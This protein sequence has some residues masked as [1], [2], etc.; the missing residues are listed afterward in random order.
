MV[1]ANNFIRNTFFIKQIPDRA[2]RKTVHV[3][4]T[5]TVFTGKLQGI[6]STLKNCTIAIAG[7]LEAIQAILRQAGE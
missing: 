5:Y 1:G 7:C 6:S 2:C 3:E 4:P